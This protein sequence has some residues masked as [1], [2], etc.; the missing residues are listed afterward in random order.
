MK[1]L[2][3]VLINTGGLYSYI[4]ITSDSTVMIEG[5]TQIVECN[6]VLVKV[7][8]KLFSVEVWGSGLALNSFS[9]STVSVT[10]S[11]C[12]VGLERRK[13]GEPL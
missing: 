2:K 12:S 8:T 3:E 7:L 10:G 11:I 5:C 13:A 1:N 4:T 6:E 9:N